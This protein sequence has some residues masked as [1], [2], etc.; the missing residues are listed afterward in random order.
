[1]NISPIA[2]VVAA[3]SALLLFNLVPAVAETKAEETVVRYMD[4]LFSGNIEEIETC[5]AE[6]LLK[7][8][9]NTLN[10][11]DYSAI[12]TD[13][14]KTATYQ[15]TRNRQL[16]NGKRTVDVE[17]TFKPGEKSR[18]RFFLNQRNLISDESI[19]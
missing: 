17:I 15:I 3:V 18:L 2:I 11:P 13:Q 12:L 19:L 6:D 9:K 16:S 7:R 1:M 4:A 10:D 5:L 8:R 14:Y